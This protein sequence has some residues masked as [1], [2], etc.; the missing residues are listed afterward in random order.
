MLPDLSW[1]H[2]IDN[3]LIYVDNYLKVM[4]IFRSKYKENIMDIELENFT[5][6]SEN[7]GKKIF[8]F[9]KLTWSEDTLNFYK[10]K[11]LYS[12]T[13]SFKQIRSK[14]ISYDKERYKPYFNL[15][16]AY[17]NIYEWLNI[18]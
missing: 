15:L 2:S 8:D 5:Q 13:L 17:K 9:C 3:I 6:N 11:N 16:D 10:R 1:A 7:L 4:N 18:N 12:K 14:I